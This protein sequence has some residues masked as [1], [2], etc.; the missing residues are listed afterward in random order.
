MSSSDEQR[1]A[2]SAFMDSEADD[3][4][5]RRIATALLND[6]DLQA[7][8]RRFHL[9]GALLRDEVGQPDT[10]RNADSR[11]A[12]LRLQAALAMEAPLSVEPAA[13]SA[14]QPRSPASTAPDAQ[15]DRGAEQLRAATPQAN[16][17]R[18]YAAGLGLA[19]AAGLAAGMW[20]GTPEG[21]LPQP[22]ATSG[23]LALQANTAVGN[24]GSAQGV[25]GVQPVDSQPIDSQPID[26]QQQ[27]AQRRA[28]LYMLM[29]AQ[30]AGSSQ[31]S[32]GISLVKFVS[33][34]QASSDSGNDSAQHN[35][36]LHNTDQ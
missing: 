9:I 18:W 13:E 1:Q 14:P 24:D 4:E 10:V 33:Y 25:G 6:A 26:S 15:F 16:G 12:T 27:D 2:L 29:H 19:T 22:S 35:S 8:W 30:Q 36:A 31:A 17:R 32:Q 11:A 21:L 20:L 7:S 3:L 28:R 34:G 5:S 23:G